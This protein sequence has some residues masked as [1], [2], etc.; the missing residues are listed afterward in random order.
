ML[1]RKTGEY[2]NELKNKYD[3]FTKYP[4]LYYQALEVEKNSPDKKIIVILP[5]G[6][7]TKLF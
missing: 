6:K 3:V 7:I 2:G 1:L 5:D 4:E